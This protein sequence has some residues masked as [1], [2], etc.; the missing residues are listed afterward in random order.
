[1]IAQ[2]GVVVSLLALHRRPRR[3]ALARAARQV[4]R[5]GILPEIARAV[6]ALGGLLAWGSVVLLV[7][8]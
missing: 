2:S 3:P 6:A 8:G 4:A 7:A 5:A 1:M